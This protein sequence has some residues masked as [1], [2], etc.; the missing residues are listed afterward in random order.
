M[1][2]PYGL[3]CL[4]LTNTF[5][6]FGLLIAHSLSYVCC[7]ATHFISEL[8]FLLVIDFRP[9]FLTLIH[10]ILGTHKQQ[11]LNILYYIFT[12][13]SKW[14]NISLLWMHRSADQQTIDEISTNLISK[15][16]PSLNLIAL[17]VL[18]VG[19]LFKQTA[20]DVF[21]LKYKFRNKFNLRYW[22]SGNRWYLSLAF[23][24]IIT[25]VD[26]FRSISCCSVLYYQDI[27]H[28]SILYQIINEETFYEETFYVW[29]L[30]NWYFA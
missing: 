27:K 4:I 19:P 25:F 21:S 5:K 22:F 16:L 15:H 23:I 10:Y 1:T 9:T 14:F 18:P 29:H 7:M 26:N 30:G 2:G 8:S 13:R 17:K 6:F 24:M 11:N 20:L 3:E 12:P 28:T